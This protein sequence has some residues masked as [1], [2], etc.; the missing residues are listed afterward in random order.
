MPISFRKSHPHIA[1]RYQVIHEGIAVGSIEKRGP[2]WIWKIYHFGRIV[3]GDAGHAA[4]SHLAETAFRAAWDRLIGPD[5]LKWF[6]QR[7]HPKKKP[8]FQ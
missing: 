5:D 7:A 3:P 4:A 1:D 2:I 6:Q 8:R